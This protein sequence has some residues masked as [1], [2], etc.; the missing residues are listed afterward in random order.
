[1][2]ALVAEGSDTDYLVTDISA[3]VVYGWSAVHVPLGR[4]CYLS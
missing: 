4:G 3:S 2:K 1:M